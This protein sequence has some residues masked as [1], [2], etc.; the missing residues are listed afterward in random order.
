M[1]AR[2]QI[3]LI[4]FSPLASVTSAGLSPPLLRLVF[5]LGGGYDIEDGVGGD[6]ENKRK[7]QRVCVCVFFMYDGE[8]QFEL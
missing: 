5:S 4:L 7:R 3:F 6:R 2:S 8:Q 1:E